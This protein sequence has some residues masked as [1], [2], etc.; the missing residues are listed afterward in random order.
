VDVVACYMYLSI[1]EVHLSHL[2][3][4]GELYWGKPIGSGKLRRI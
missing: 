1:I 3:H 2:I 4:W